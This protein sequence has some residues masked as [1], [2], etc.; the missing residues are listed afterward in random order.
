MGN[1]A[2]QL[3]VA[4]TLT[5]NFGQRDFNAAFFT[6]HSTVLQALVLTAQTLVVFDRAKD[7]GA[8]Q[9]FAL[10]LEGPVVNR[11]RLLDLTKGPR[12]DHLRRSQTDSNGIKFVGLRPETSTVG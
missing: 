10:G 6:D 4:H 2:G 12:T 9:T 3:D 7:L 8:E 5:A 11:F 1:R